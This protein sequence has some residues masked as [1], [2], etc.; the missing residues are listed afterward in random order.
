M[1]TGERGLRW[2]VPA[3]VLLFIAFVS[4]LLA[5]RWIDAGNF[6]PRVPWVT[7]GL[8]AGIAAV[9]LWF[10]Y[11]VRS[12]QR[13]RKADLSPLRA[14]RTLALAQAAALTGAALGGFYLG[15]AIALLPDRDLQ[16]VHGLL[17]RFGIGILAGL[18]LVVSGMIAQNWCRIP[19]R[20]DTA[21]D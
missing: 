19:P 4:A 14:A 7:I 20:D 2:R 10:G 5:K 9:V 16:A 12:Y 18:G 1:G 17:W 15:Q 13:G 3:L 8:L 11:A 6:P 21:Q